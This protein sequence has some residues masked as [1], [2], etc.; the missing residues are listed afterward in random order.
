VD[1]FNLTLLSRLQWILLCILD[2]CAAGHVHDLVE[3]CLQINGKV[4]QQAL[5]T[6]KLYS[7]ELIVIIVK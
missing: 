1:L 4:I 3:K 2:L 5:V 7:V 6:D